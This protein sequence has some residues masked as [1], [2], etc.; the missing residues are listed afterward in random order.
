M[1]NLQVLKKKVCWNKLFSARTEF[2]YIPT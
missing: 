2:R 1:K